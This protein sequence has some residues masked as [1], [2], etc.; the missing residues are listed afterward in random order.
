MCVTYNTLKEIQNSDVFFTVSQDES[1]YGRPE[2]RSRDF[3][4][5]IFG[6]NILLNLIN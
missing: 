6:L 1:E 3:S 5:Q 4:S 2:F